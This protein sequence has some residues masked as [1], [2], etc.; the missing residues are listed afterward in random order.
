M[1]RNDLAEGDGQQRQDGSSSPSNGTLECPPCVICA[2]TVPAPRVKLAPAIVS[3][4]H[5]GAGQSLSLKLLFKTFASSHESI[6]SQQSLIKRLN[7]AHAV[8]RE[9]AKVPHARSYTASKTRMQDPARGSALLGAN[10]RGHLN[11]L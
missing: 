7:L 3:V 9:A 2:R 8:C 11:A 5:K 4:R 10:I 6:P 1:N